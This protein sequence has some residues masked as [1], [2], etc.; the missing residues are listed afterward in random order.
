[1]YLHSGMI[2]ACVWNMEGEGNPEVLGGEPLT[3]LAPLTSQGLIKM[4]AETLTPRSMPRMVPHQPVQFVSSPFG[5]S[6]AVE[7]C[8]AHK[9]LFTKA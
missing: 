2:V 5:A 9:I 4:D 7:D 8:A 6:V 1:M 3:D